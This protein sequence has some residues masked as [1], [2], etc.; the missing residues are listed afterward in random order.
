MGYMWLQ[1]NVFNFKY[2]LQ[3]YI[4][5]EMVLIFMNDTYFDDNQVN[6]RYIVNELVVL[7]NVFL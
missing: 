3:D 4:L 7:I 6:G 2:Q 1:T 5:I